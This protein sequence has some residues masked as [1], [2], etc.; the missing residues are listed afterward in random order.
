MRSGSPALLRLTGRT[1]TDPRRLRRKGRG[2]RRPR[3]RPALPDR[4]L[5][6]AIV[7]Q[8]EDQKA[9]PVGRKRRLKLSRRTG[10]FQL[11]RALRSAFAAGRR[12]SSSDASAAR[13]HAAL[14]RYDVEILREIFAN[15]RH[16]F[17]AARAGRGRLLLASGAHV[18]RG[19]CAGLVK[20]AMASLAASAFG[21]PGSNESAASRCWRA[22]AARPSCAKT[23]PA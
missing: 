11:L 4:L 8:F 2:P 18:G 7:V 9:R 21:K 19:Y 6:H 20:L 5:H 16:R 10:V 3:R 14:G 13:G 23:M 15:P 12:H 22:S 1:T 17:A